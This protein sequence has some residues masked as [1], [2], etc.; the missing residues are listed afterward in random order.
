MTLSGDF[1]E[2]L[3]KI[4]D[5]R[6][7]P[8]RTIGEQEARIEKRSRLYVAALAGTTIA[9]TVLLSSVDQ[10]VGNIYVVAL[11][12][13][14]AAIAERG[15]VELRSGVSHSIS[16]VPTL[17]AAVLCGPL[18]A[19]LVAAASFLGE[20]RR[21]YL[22]WASYTSSRVLTAIATGFAALAV[23]ASIPS[24]LVSVGGAPHA[25]AHI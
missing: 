10:G 5:I 12:G 9:V 15:R 19:G 16:L 3:K 24:R 8:L 13:L 6:D 20:F 22:R 2:M 18:A 23:H 25:A 14:V 17:F 4:E 1:Q 11:L 21:P 7:E